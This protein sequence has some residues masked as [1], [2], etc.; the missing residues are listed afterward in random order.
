M[1]TVTLDVRPDLLEGREPFSKIMETVAGLGPEDSLLLI[2]PFQPVPLFQVLA[3][4]GLNYKSTPTE[5]GDWEV[6]FTPKNQR[7]KVEVLDVDA[8]GLEPPQPLVAIIEAVENQSKSDKPKQIRAL[9]DRRPQHLYPAL[10]ERG[11]KAET[12]E[13]PDGSFTTLIKKT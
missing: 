2:A 12:T 10:E 6:L 7:A 4:K 11:W 3:K 9:T 1:K 13:E 5:T 8:R